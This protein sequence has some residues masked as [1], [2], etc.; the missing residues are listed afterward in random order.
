MVTLALSTLETFVLPTG[1][2]YFARRCSTIYSHHR[3]FHFFVQPGFDTVHF[4]LRSINIRTNTNSAR[5]CQA[6]S[7]PCTA[8]AECTCAENSRKGFF[9]PQ[10]SLTN[11][12]SLS[13]LSFKT[14][15]KLKNKNYHGPHEHFSLR[16][17]NIHFLR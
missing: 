2:G 6:L 16:V 4:P 13:C 11:L 12:S 15:W 1:I 14:L 7:H 9:F 8:Q 5:S 3:Y 17:P 10:T